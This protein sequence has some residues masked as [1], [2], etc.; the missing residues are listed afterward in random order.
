[1]YA[2]EW[3][4]YVLDS[5]VCVLTCM[6]RHSVLIFYNNYRVMTC[7]DTVSSIFCLAII[8]GGGGGAGVILKYIIKKNH[9]VVLVKF[10]GENYYVS[11][12]VETMHKD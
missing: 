11:H 6:Y 3:D 12:V 1:M 8:G 10:V 4:K 5:L 2:E 9:K 7:I